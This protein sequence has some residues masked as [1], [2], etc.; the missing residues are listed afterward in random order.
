MRWRDTSGA[1]MSCAAARNVLHK[2]G[3]ARS[4]A[5]PLA[6][7][8]AVGFHSGRGAWGPLSLRLRAYPRGRLVRSL[9]EKVFVA[10]S[11]SNPDFPLGHPPCSASGRHT[12]S[13]PTWSPTASAR[14]PPAKAGPRH[15]CFLL[16]LWAKAGA[17][18]ACR[19][20]GGGPPRLAVGSWRPLPPAAFGTPA[21]TLAGGGGV[22]PRWRDAPHTTPTQWRH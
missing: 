18:R 9:Q 8:L 4:C 13:W 20:G 11:V 10:R 2:V 1:P 3:L 16:S 5:L 14:R 22:E 15:H 12:P 6:H 19:V 21:S 17:A 7:W